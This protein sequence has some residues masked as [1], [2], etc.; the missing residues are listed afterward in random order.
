MVTLAAPTR[1]L[2]AAGFLGTI[3]AA[4]YVTTRYGMVP[5]GFGLVAIAGTYFAGL[6]FV[7][8]DELQ[9]T[10]GK[11]ATVGVIVVGAGLSYLLADPMIA[12]ASAVAFGVSEFAD[13]GVYTPL[14]RRGYLKAVTASNVVGTVVDSLLFLAI[15]GFPVMLALPGQLVGKLTVTAVFVALV[16]AWRL[17]RRVAVA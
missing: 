17:G 8:R 2:L 1:L 4:N 5:V 16:G 15:A 3:L 7:L 10:A 12:T 11:R 9:R 14:R 6:A 13:M